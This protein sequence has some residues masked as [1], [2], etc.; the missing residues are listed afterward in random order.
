ML[1]LS[2][3]SVV[4]IVPIACCVLR[5]GWCVVC[6]VW[7]VVCGVWCV[8]CGVW[9]VVCGVWCVVRGARCAVCGARCGAYCVDRGLGV[10]AWVCVVL[11]VGACCLGL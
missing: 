7:C 1:L 10:G 9:C 8:V 4:L 3:V 6:G 5:G 11:R 2:I